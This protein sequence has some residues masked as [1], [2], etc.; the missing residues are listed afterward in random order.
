[1]QSDGGTNIPAALRT[2]LSALDGAGAGRVRRIVL[3][4]DGLDGQRDESES[5]ARAASDARAT[6]SSLGIGLD[7]DEAYMSSVARLGRG[8]FGFVES[9]SALSR[10]LERELEQTAATTVERI[11]ARIRLPAGMRLLRAVG[12]E[13]R[14]VNGGTVEV[15]VGSLFAGDERRVVL[16]LAARGNLGDSLRLDGEV[17]WQP[18]GGDSAHAAIDALHLLVSGDAEAV[19]ATRDGAVYGRAVSAL[20]SL[21]Q[22]EAAQAYARG[23]TDVADGIIA[24][25]LADLGKAKQ[26]APAPVAA[27]LEEQ[28]KS[29][30][31]TRGSF[32]AA[33]PGSAEGRAAS[34]AA[35]EKDN[36]NLDRAAF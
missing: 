9:A 36:A 12:G 18:V 35:T 11:A 17:S 24:D 25:N 13:A 21:R 27:R 3:V 8:N 2:A 31:D 33:E 5:L 20:A 15:S 16:E 28:E 34:K 7:F 4:S 14:E 26:A 22:L 32:Q 30:R 10:F 1:M 19:A 29:Y 6:V 23:E